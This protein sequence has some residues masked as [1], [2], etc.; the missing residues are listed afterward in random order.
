MTPIQIKNGHIIRFSLI[1]QIT[2]G[3]IEYNDKFKREFKEH[4]RKQLESEI[5]KRCKTTE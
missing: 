4:T 5:T 2:D 3:H 1:Y